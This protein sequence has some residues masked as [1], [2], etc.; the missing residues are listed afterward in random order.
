MPPPVPGPEPAVPQAARVSS[1]PDPRMAGRY[2]YMVAISM[3]NVSSHSGSWIVWFAEHQPEPGAPRDMRPP[4]AVH[5]VDPKY[6]PSAAA[7]HVEGRVRLFA[8]IGKDGRVGG[9]TVLEHLDA[10]L[11]RSAVEALA[12][13]EFEPALRDGIPVDVD[14]VFDI[15]FH[16]EHPAVK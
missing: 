1:S 7:E 3:P 11:D 12:K 4:I 6:I 2:I 8:V 13:W 9:I 10:R 5:K 14:A 15:P 16:L